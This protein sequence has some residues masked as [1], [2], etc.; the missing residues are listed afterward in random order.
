MYLNLENSALGIKN[1]KKV[2]RPEK[3]GM[4]NGINVSTG[5]QGLLLLG[6]Y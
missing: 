1:K 4:I 6:G 2:G 3:T 5:T